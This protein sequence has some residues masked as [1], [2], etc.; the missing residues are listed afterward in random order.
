MKNSLSILILL[1][2]SSALIS[3]VDYSSYED[4]DAEATL[5]LNKIYNS[6]SQSEDYKIEFTLNI[7]FPGYQ[8]EVQKGILLQSGSNYMFNNGDQAIY[9]YND[10]IWTHHVSQKE[11]YI[12]ERNLEDGE[13]NLG[14]SPIQLLGTY[15]SKD[16][17]YAILNTEPFE[18]STRYFI[19]FKPL[20]D[21]PD[22]SKIRVN[23]IDGNLPTLESIVVF[24]KDGSRYSISLDNIDTEIGAKDSDFQ[25]DATKYPGIHIED[26]RL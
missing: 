10:T 16:F 25:F 14:L 4:S 1:L 11:V 12:D 8:P 23:V 6:I 5:L 13:E 7:E 17:V 24:N 15:Q 9:A 3:Q 2:T 19:E 18:S 21:N 26:I 22:Y 20:V